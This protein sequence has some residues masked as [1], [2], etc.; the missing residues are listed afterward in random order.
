MG[1]WAERYCVLANYKLKVYKEKLDR[2][3]VEEYNTNDLKLVGCLALKDDMSFY[4]QL[5]DQQNFI[6]LAENSDRRNFW[7]RSI[8]AW[9]VVI[10]N[11]E[12]TPKLNRLDSFGGSVKELFQ[13]RPRNLTT[14]DD[15]EDNNPL[16][17]LGLESADSMDVLTVDEF[18]L[19]GQQIRRATMEY[20]GIQD[21]AE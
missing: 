8:A 3:P 13:T 1:N 2:E 19:A 15:I 12:E 17:A 11:P 7:V 18:E 21:D 20:D 6:F 4:I 9:G 14:G 5:Q 16:A 10:V